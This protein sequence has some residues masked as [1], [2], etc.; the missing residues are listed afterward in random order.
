[1]TV[2]HRDVH[3]AHSPAVDRDAAVSAMREVLSSVGV[4]CSRPGLDRTADRFVDVALARF[5]SAAAPIELPVDARFPVRDVS[6]FALGPVR[7]HSTCE[8]HLL[9]FEG[10]VRVAVVPQGWTVGLGRTTDLIEMA[11]ARL[12]LQER[13]TTEL[14]E[15]PRSGLDA[16][17][18]LVRIDARHSCLWACGHADP[19]T[20]MST[21]SFSGESDTAIRSSLQGAVSALPRR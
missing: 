6:T 10:S 1:M 7:F 21:E 17:G 5:G 18:V 14:A 12:Q 4:D 9:P 16:R 2:P 3:H 19:R 13:L 11:A 8:H 15:A 20:R